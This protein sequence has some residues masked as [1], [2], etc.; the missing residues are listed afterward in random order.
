MTNSRGVMSRR[1]HRRP[2][3]VPR[4]GLWSLLASFLHTGAVRVETEATVD[5]DRLLCFVSTIQ[6]DG[7]WMLEIHQRAI[8]RHDLFGLHRDQVVAQLRSLQRLNAIIAY[9]PWSPVIVA[10]VGLYL[11][12]DRWLTITGYGLASSVLLTILRGIAGRI[13]RGVIRLFRPLIANAFNR[14][15]DTP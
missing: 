11:N 1:F 7:D 15:D 14:G 5:G 3:I 8:D 13:I 2:E 12:P 10:V 6:L 9:L 4:E